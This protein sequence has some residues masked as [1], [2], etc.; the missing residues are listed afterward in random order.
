METIKKNVSI[1]GSMLMASLKS[2]ME[3]RVDFI[4]GML[5]QMI[6]QVVELIFIWIIFQNTPSLAGWNMEQLLLLYGITMLSLAFTDFFFDSIYDI[7]P[8]YI[9]DG[10]FD[11]ILLRPVHP[12]LSI[13]GD[14]KAFTAVGYLLLGIILTIS[15]LVK[16]QIPITIMLI[17][18]ILFFGMIG[19][20]MVG[21]IMVIFS[22]TSF[23]TYKSNEIIW[24]VFK[25]YTFAQYPITIYNT[26][27]RILITCILPFAFI[28]YYPALNYLQME[29]GWVIYIAPMVVIIFWIIA[30]KIWNAALRKY[31]S[32]GS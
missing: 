8:K 30:V 5:S 19:A 20:L 31:R 2:M 27:L 16:L 18:K 11:K 10:D 13:I 6:T 12:L 26:F 7:G 25:M 1:Y 28:A 15:M 9:K 29:Q 21:A 24:S 22:I 23:Y 17:L 14:S 32:T 4:V 3:Y